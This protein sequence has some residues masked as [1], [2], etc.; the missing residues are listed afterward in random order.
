MKKNKNKNKNNN[1]N[2]K[3]HTP[4]QDSVRR[5][6]RDISVAMFLQVCIS[7]PLPRF[8]ERPWKSKLFRSQSIDSERK[9]KNTQNTNNVGR[10]KL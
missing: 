7:P 3:K 8:Q 6:I 10:G 5:Y 9:Q 1:N 4:L 2:N